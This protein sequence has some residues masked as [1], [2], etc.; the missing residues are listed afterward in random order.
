MKDIEVKKGGYLF[1]VS[2]DK[3]NMDYKILTPSERTS[4]LKMDIKMAGFIEESKT[5]LNSSQ[6]GRYNLRVKKL[7]LM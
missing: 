1:T 6:L 7:Y 5:K 2:I 4:V 3:F